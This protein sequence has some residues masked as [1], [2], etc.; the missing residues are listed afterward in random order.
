[1]VIMV[2]MVVKWPGAKVSFKLDTGNED[3][4]DDDE[5]VT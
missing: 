1:M 3:D 4:G 5:E 2:R